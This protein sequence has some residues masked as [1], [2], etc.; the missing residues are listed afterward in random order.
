MN[1]MAKYVYSSTLRDPIWSN[2]TVVTDDLGPVV[3]R[4]KGQIEG[5]ILVAGFRFLV[6]ALID[7][8]AVDELRLMVF[9]VI[10]GGGERLVAESAS[11]P[12][13]LVDAKTIGAGVQVLVY[14]P[15]DR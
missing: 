13:R 10:L 7:D 4:L 1:T 14:R 8:D 3:R 11:R 12:L 9:P 2:T 6:R 15:A 5:V